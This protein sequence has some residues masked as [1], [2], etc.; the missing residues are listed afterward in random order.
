MASA[1]S[2]ARQGITYHA[3]QCEEALRLAASAAQEG[4]TDIERGLR[5]LARIHATDAWRWVPR[6]GTPR[7]DA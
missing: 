4:L 6:L 7:A 2:A 5:K 3:T 1:A